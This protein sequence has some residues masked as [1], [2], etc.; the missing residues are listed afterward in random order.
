MISFPTLVESV[1]INEVCLCSGCSEGLYILGF[2]MAHDEE[3][4]L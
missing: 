4:F 2:T 1:L 3:P